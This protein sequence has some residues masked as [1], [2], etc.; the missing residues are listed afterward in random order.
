M[1]FLVVEDSKVFAAMFRQLLEQGGHEIEVE[2]DSQRTLERIDEVQPDAVLLD[3]MMPHV[4]GMAVLRR[5]REHCGPDLKVIIVSAKPYENDR[6]SALALGAAGYINKVA[7]QDRLLQ[8]I[9]EIMADR[10][11]L[12]FWGVRGTLPVPG[13]QALRYGG[14]TSCL[15]LEFADGRLFIF[16]AG[17]GIKALSDRL[18]AAGRTEIKARIFI[19]H[20]HW[21]HINALP[22]FAPLYIKGNEFEIL[23]VGQQDKSIEDLIS[24]QMDGVYFPVTVSEFGARVSYRE[25]NEGSFEVDGVSIRTMLLNHPG[26]CLGYRIEYRDVIFC[27]VTDNELYPESSAFYNADYRRQLIDFVK[28]ADYLVTDTTYTAEQYAAGKEHWGHS[29]IDEVVAIADQANVRTLC[30]FHHDPDQSD[31]DI[32]AKLAT[33][34]R[35]LLERGSATVVIAPAENSSI[36]LEPVAT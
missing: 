22:F 24:G 2:L 9:E 33:A 36:S 25:L 32:D 23:G 20:P 18:L 15:T 13:Q 11:L 7:E 8:R 5:I 28:D 26:N 1:K 35:L 17:T 4:D 31:A 27:Y 30:L 10:P 16:D 34:K 14:N 3:L 12:T 29:S 6:R 21:D 19:S